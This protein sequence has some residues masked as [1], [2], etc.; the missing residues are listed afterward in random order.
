VVAEIFAI[1]KLK[2][3]VAINTDSSSKM[4]ELACLHHN[5]YFDQNW[6]GSS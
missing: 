2:T 4:N 3:L 6:A 1:T 5:T